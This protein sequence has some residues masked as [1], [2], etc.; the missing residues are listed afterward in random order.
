[1]VRSAEILGGVIVTAFGALG[2]MVVVVRQPL[3][4]YVACKHGSHLCGN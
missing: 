2:K 3:T 1:M 4:G